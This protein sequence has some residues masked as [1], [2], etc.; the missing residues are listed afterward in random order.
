MSRCAVT[1]VRSLL[2]ARP[3]S[4]TLAAGGP[5]IGPTAPGHPG[6]QEPR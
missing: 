3:P 1:I 2:A 6:G 5:I 4:L